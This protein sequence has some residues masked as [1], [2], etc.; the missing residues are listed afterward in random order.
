MRD[1]GSFAGQL[2]LRSFDRAERVY[3]AMK[4]RGY[5]LGYITGYASGYAL[6][7]IPRKKEPLLLK[8]FVFLLIVFVLCAA[9]RFID[10]NA[11]L[12]VFFGRFV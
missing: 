12:T 11:L 2:L 10:I 7:N 9:F 5:A 3:N 8:D 4:C 6:Q 1:M